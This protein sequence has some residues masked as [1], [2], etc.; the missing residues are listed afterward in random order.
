MRLRVRR[1]VRLI[2]PESDTRFGQEGL[3]LSDFESDLSYVVLGEPGMG[4]STEFEMEAKRIGTMR[5]VPARRFIRGKPENHPEWKNGPIFIDGLDEARAAGQYPRKVVDRIIAQLEDLDIPQFRLSCRSASW[6][7]AGD[8]E[9]L[10]SLS[11]SRN[12]PILQLN[13][14]NHR[15]IKQILSQQVDHAD[16]FIMQA[17]KR[18]MEIFLSNPQLLNLLIRS[19]ADNGWPE[20]P[21]AM[22]EHA[23]RE[24]LKEQNREHRD[25][26]LTS[27]Q[28]S[29]S[30]V[31]NA[32]GHLSALIL[33]AGK[34]GCSLTD[35]DESNILPLHDIENQDRIL[36]YKAFNSRFFEGSS[37]YRTPI[38]RLLA[39]YLGARYLDDKIQGGLSIRRV[40]ALLMGHDGVPFPDLRGLAGWLAAF[41]PKARAT[42]IR[43]DPIAVAFNGDASSFKPDE[44]LQLLENLERSIDFRYSWPSAAALGALAG[45]QSI[46]VIQ[47]LVNSKNHSK[48]R[49]KLIYMLLCGIS[50]RSPKTYT[51]NGQIPPTHSE[52]DRKILL[53]I[54]YN[55]D[56]RSNVRCEA[57][58]AL[59]NMLT[60]CPDRG[61]I[62][63]RFI[64][65]LDENSLSDHGNDLRGIVL[66]LLYPG[67]LR[68]KN[69]WK[70]LTTRSTPHQHDNH[71]EFWSTLVER[72]QEEQVRELLDS[73]CDH[74][75]EILPK[76][77]SHRLAD[78]ALI[79]LARG[80]DLFG[81]ELSIKELYRWFDLV[82]FD[83]ISYQLVPA[84]GANQFYG[85]YNHNANAAIW[86]W[87]NEHESTQRALIEHGVL[88]NQP[89][90][91]NK[92][93]NK[94]VG[95]KFIGEDAPLGFRSWCLARA[96]E[97]WNSQQ[98]L[99][100]ELA[101]WSVRPED[102]WGMPLSDDEVAQ[103]VLN[104]PGLRK[105][106]DLRLQ[107]RIQTDMREAMSKRTMQPSHLSRS[108]RQRLQAIE[109]L[110]RHKKELVA[111]YCHPE[112]LRDLARIYFY[113]LNEVEAHPR[114]SLQSYLDG[115]QPLTRMVLA[116]FQSLLKRD[117][118]P[119][120]KQ[121]AEFYR[122]GKSSHFALP[123]LAGIEE[124]ERETG[125][126][127]NQLSEK[128]KRRAIGFYLITD[129][130]QRQHVPLNYQ[131]SQSNL[132]EW[133]KK[134]VKDCPQAVSD[135]LVA[136]H[137]ACVRSKNRPN[138]HLLNM[139]FDDAYASVSKL[140]VRRMFT[141]FPTRC[142]GHQ[143]DSLRAVLQIAILAHGMSDEELKKLTL[144]R[145][146]RKDMDIGQRAQW[147]CSGLFVAQDT[148][149]PLLTDFLSDGNPSHRIRHVINFLAPTRHILPRLLSVVH[150][151][152]SQTIF[153][154]L[155]TLGEQVKPPDS[156][157]LGALTSSNQ[158]IF[159]QP[160]VVLFGAWIQALSER[161]D[162]DSSQELDS[163]TSNRNLSA[164][165]SIL[166][167]A[168]NNQDQLRRLA[169]RP[170]IDLRQI[171]KA[172][173]NG[174]PINA[175]DLTSITVNALEKLADD[176]R[177]ENTSDWRQYWHWN[178]QTRKSTKP[179]NENDCRNALL[180]DL[181]RMLAHHRI[182]AQ[183]EGHYADDKRADIRVS[184]GTDL[185]IPIEI[186]RNSDR[187]IW[188]GISEQLVPKYTRDPKADGNGIYLVFWFGAEYMRIVPPQGT[189]PN[190]PEE[191]K[192]LLEK[193]LDPQL[194]NKI[195]VVVVDVSPSDHIND[196][197]KSSDH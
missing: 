49:Q 105:W 45:N 47:E 191:L 143:L 175:S 10:D 99:A 179:Q 27:P 63:R 3:S 87:L 192:D 171:Q 71:L 114:N 75:S 147:L 107:N 70:Y 44:R 52:N 168:Q 30:E 61:L 7:G 32:A 154:L 57:L 178:P 9:E 74:A 195:H 33:I 25:A 94:T 28:P 53:E 196:S 163:L 64:E 56:W 102:G 128:G 95:L 89:N 159:D 160:I 169:R 190:K 189:C 80:L 149:L 60:G 141:V 150:G 6:L 37:S 134:A 130:P 42:L 173:Q 135:S 13:P 197:S 43:T 23:C 86:N 127:L 183:P 146:K 172:L 136:I 118:L 34:D 116:G 151:W 66:Y 153:Y 18:R 88:A 121:I 139:I 132:S 101:F 65:D 155:Q 39:E 110:Q 51:G 4:K 176:I 41:N 5:P 119:D 174:P 133:Y 185:A 193:R 26:H 120:L 62:L 109:Y 76:L 108:E 35:T 115:D 131:T 100:E 140:S 50:Q 177:N 123:F 54:I 85:A 67:E 103:Q 113:A 21:H 93:L 79:L 19:I 40:F 117:D 167:Q 144:R 97:L 2:S 145:L 157:E 12:T 188:E 181:K 194:R 16:K 182:D 156:Y 84:S 122:Q 11:N 17:H 148:C 138:E 165:K 29:Q 96:I 187:K 59:N 184:F 126:V 158:I 98:N 38:H 164:W 166:L 170:V 48:N 129:L 31:L 186:K 15:D 106:N 124:E 14:L 91:G 137:D 46:S 161:I 8:Q 83:I 78:T 111:G 82:K 22:F 77:A 69:V 152:K 36:L 90:I 81:D 112:I 104:I 72:S 1:T 24:F 20:S 125:D 180:S 68:A 55:S 73:L 162:D 92:P 142:T 58:R